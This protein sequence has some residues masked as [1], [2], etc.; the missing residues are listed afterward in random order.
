MGSSTSLQK[1]NH[2]QSWN[3][4]KTRKYKSTLDCVDGYHDIELDEEYRRAPKGYLSSG[5][6]YGR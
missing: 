1:W 2:N 4:A 3:K 6:S 5:D